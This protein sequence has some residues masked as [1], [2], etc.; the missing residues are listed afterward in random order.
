ML[1]A[2]CHSPDQA[3]QAPYHSALSTS[4]N[5]APTASLG[6]LFQYLTPLWVKNFFLT[7]NL[8]LLSFSLKLFPLALLLSD[9]VKSLSPFLCGLKLLPTCFNGYI[10]IPIQQHS[11]GS[12]AFLKHL[13]MLPKKKKKKKSQQF[14]GQSV[15]DVYLKWVLHLCVIG[16][17]EELRHEFQMN[18]QQSSFQMNTSGGSSS[19]QLHYW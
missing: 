19:Q 6:N 17:T 12:S 14:S 7:S 2:D 5:G 8:N 13:H 1:W 3:V 11:Q 4:R 9:H 15:K 16:D 10:F 18:L